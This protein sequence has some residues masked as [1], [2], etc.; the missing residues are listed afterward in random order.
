VNDVFH[1]HYFDIIYFFLTLNYELVCV[2]DE[3]F[4]NRNCYSFCATADKIVMSNIK[5][6]IKM[7]LVLEL[8]IVAGILLL[9]VLISFA[10]KLNQNSGR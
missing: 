3:A 9:I 10:N 1:R 8:G 7:H 4:S 5:K 2:E 6:K